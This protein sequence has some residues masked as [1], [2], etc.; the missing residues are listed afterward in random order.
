MEKWKN[1]AGFDYQVSNLGRVRS[2]PRKVPGRGDKGFRSIGGQLLKGR[3]NGKGHLRV[4]LARDGVH[5]DVL[6]SRLVATYFVRNPKDLPLVVHKDFDRSNN[7]AS[8]LMWC[9][10][11]SSL[12][13]ALGA[14]RFTALTSPKRAKNLDIETVELIYEL[15]LAGMTLSEIS[16][17]LDVRVEAAANVCNGKAWRDAS[18]PALARRRR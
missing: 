6:I 15:R 1:I 13:R 9:D 2:L 12:K 11:A 14:G 17:A 18:R 8:N 16:T 5:R 7:A 10:Q 4:N 3:P